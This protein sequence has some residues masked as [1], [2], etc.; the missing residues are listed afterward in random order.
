M[1]L[2]KII[3]IFVVYVIF[4]LIIVIQPAKKTQIALLIAKKMQIL[5]KYSDFSNIFLKKK[6]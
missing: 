2:N 5:F 6:V 3:E 4:L 1:V